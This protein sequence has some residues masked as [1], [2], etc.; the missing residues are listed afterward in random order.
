MTALTDAEFMKFPLASQDKG[1]GFVEYNPM[2]G[3]GVV[4]LPRIDSLTDIERRTMSV[5]ELAHLAFPMDDIGY[6]LFGKID[7]ERALTEDEVF[8]HKI[9]GVVLDL[10][11]DGAF[12]LLTQQIAKSW[13]EDLNVF[14]GGQW[15][16]EETKEYNRVLELGE[17]SL[18]AA[19]VLALDSLR[20]ERIISTEN[21]SQI[22]LDWG[23]R[24]SID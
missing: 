22:M 16:F 9:G 18:V 2:L 24:T 21:M 8:A 10:E 12:S 23:A 4:T 14:D 17:F 13:A 7:G 5:H 1:M 15:Y 3:I 20:N 19:H 11:T 6:S